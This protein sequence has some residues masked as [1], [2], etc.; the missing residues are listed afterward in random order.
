MALRT[1]YS[2]EEI[3]VLESYSHRLNNKVHITFPGGTFGDMLWS[4][5]FVTNASSLC[6]LT[7]EG[8]VEINQ[9]KIKD[10]TH[11]AFKLGNAVNDELETRHDI[12]FAVY[13]GINNS[14]RGDPIS[15]LDDK[16]NDNELIIIDVILSHCCD[17][18]PTGLM[19]LFET[20]FNQK[21][22]FLLPNKTDAEFYGEICSR[23]TDINNEYD[24]IFTP[25]VNKITENITD[26]AL[27]INPNRFVIDEEVYTECVKQISDFIEMKVDADI[28]SKMVSYRTFWCNKQ[29]KYILDYNFKI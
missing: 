9:N 25:N 24:W 28:I 5:I 14:T 16:N 15:E 8:K 3:E 6:P 7:S 27:V 10:I 21:L 29:P 12:L 18:S 11:F 4:S 26:N 22:I 13:M 20:E 17:E 19:D 1:Q 2:S 23:K